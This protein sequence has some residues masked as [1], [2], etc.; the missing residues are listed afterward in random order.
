MS[1]NARQ[2]VDKASQRFFTVNVSVSGMIVRVRVLVVQVVC[3]LRQGFAPV[4][5]GKTFVSAWV[6]FNHG[7]CAVVGVYIKL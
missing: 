1:L 3:L 5:Q 6:S 2:P 7:R 4:I